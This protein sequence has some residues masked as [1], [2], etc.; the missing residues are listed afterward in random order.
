MVIGIFSSIF[1]DEA[2]LVKRVKGSAYILREGKELTIA[3]GTKLFEKD[4]IFTN[5]ILGRSRGLILIFS[6]CIA[7]QNFHNLYWQE[8]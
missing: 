1:A 6:S 8:L 2:A 7:I 5:S 4:I 3:V